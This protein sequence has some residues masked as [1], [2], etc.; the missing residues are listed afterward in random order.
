M[1]DPYHISQN[2][3]LVY[4][5]FIIHDSGIPLYTKSFQD[6]DQTRLNELSLSGILTIISNIIQQSLRADLWHIDAKGFSLFFT[7]LTEQY[8]LVIVSDG[9][10]KFFLKHI[11]K[12]SASIPTDL[13]ENV[14]NF[15]LDSAFEGL[16]DIYIHKSLPFLTR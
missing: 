16:V 6:L 12:L 7:S 13:F 10:N 11:E 1:V 9:F 15:K 3:I 4:N 5:I 8:K 2:P 14:K